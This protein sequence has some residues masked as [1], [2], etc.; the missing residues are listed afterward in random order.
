MKNK[1]SHMSISKSVTPKMQFWNKKHL[2]RYKNTTLF[3][4]FFKKNEF[5]QN[6]E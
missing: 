3:S 4:T 1:M 2:Q 6:I 5:Q